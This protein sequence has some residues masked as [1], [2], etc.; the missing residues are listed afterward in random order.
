M[1]ISATKRGHLRT[2]FV[3]KNHEDCPRKTWSFTHDR[4]QDIVVS[5]EITILHDL[6]VGGQTISCSFRV[7][8]L[9]R[10]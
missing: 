8:S 1:S 5:I 10:P 3:S 2:E 6:D 9:H 4:D 7:L